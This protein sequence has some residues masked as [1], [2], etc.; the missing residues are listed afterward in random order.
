M[1]E[2]LQPTV[3][4]AGVLSSEFVV[5]GFK[6]CNRPNYPLVVE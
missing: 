4:E 5:V 1:R 6:P 3:V 2:E